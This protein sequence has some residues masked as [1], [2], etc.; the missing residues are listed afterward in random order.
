MTLFQLCSLLTVERSKYAIIYLEE[1]ARRNSDKG[2]VLFAPV[3]EHHA[4]KAY[5]GT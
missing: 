1:V 3:F 4:G 2:E 5:G